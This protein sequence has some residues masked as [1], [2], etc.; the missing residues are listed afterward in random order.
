[1]R[2][3]F[4]IRWENTLKP[5]RDDLLL[6]TPDIYPTLLDI[7]GVSVEGQPVLDGISILPLIDGQM[8]SRTKPMGF[9]RCRTPSLREI[10]GLGCTKLSKRASGYKMQ[11]VRLD[12]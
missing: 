10:C 5:R 6:S 1:M 8:Q 11:G 4:I 2:V 7:A 12:R 9:W 3:P